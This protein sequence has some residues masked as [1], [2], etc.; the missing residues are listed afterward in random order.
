MNLKVELSTPPVSPFCIIA[1]IKK[2][3]RKYDAIM[4]LVGEEMTCHTIQ[5]VI[6]NIVLLKKKKL[7]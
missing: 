5:I 4:I 7:D 6:D 3:W 2:R 1:V